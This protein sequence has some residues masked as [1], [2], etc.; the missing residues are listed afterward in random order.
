MRRFIPLTCAVLAGLFLAGRPADAVATASRA[1]P[2]AASTAPK[3][4]LSVTIYGYTELFPGYSCTWYANVSGGT[5]P[6]TYHWV[7]MGMIE[8]YSSGD[9]WT[10]HAAHIGQVG[11]DVLVTDAYGDQGWGTLVMFSSTTHDPCW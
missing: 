1:A 10:G 11:L 9:T 6:Y 2:P 4:T 7:K 8:D 5:P 3:Q